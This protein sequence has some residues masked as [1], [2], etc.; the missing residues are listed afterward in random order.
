MGSLIQ[1]NKAIAKRKGALAAVAAGGSVAVAVIASPVLGILG[2]AG[3][4]YLGYEWF[5][6]RAKNGMR[7]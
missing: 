3:A 5:T 6:F 4:A 2:L 1:R 7:F